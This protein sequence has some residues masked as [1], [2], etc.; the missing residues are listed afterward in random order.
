MDQVKILKGYL[1]QILLGPFL[2]TLSQMKVHLLYISVG[3]MSR[4]ICFT[5]SGGWPD[6]ER[7][8]TKKM[9]SLLEHYKQ[10]THQDKVQKERQKLTK[11]RTNMYLMVRKM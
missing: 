8:F 9:A 7:P 10:V 2:N 6:Q 11:R 4:F 1:P 5:A 3:P